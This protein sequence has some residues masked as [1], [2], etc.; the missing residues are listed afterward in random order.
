LYANASH[1]NVTF[2]N[3][4]QPLR[5]RVVATTDRNVLNLLWSSATSTAPTLKWG[6]ESGN[7]TVTAAATTTT[8]TKSAMCGG[9][10][11]GTG[12]REQVLIHTA[13]LTGMAALASRRIYYIFGDAA[14]TDFA[15]E[16]VLLVPPQPGVNPQQQQLQR[17]T[18]AVLFCDL[19]RGSSDDTFTWNEYGRPALN[20]SNSIGAL[21]AAGKVDVIFHGGDISYA[22]GYMAVW[23]FFLN[24]ISGMASGAVYLST[25]GNH[26]SDWPGTASFYN[27]TDSGGECGVATTRLLPQPV[28]TQGS[29]PQDPTNQPWW[30]YEVGLIHFVGL[31]S[32]HNFTMGSAQWL[33]LEADLASVNR[34]VTPWVILNLHRAMYICVLG[35]VLYQYCLAHLELV[36]T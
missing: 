6:V 20:T 16:H 14:T 4:N 13:P 23:D 36:E 28:D 12:W 8:I 27:G 3:P 1:V 30:S 7:Y 5:P 26:E 22:R 2:A 29:P 21:V 18:T 15:D 34:S 17:P 25:V 24:M 31:S 10:A 35:P 33:W 19:G 32:E 11:N 9:E